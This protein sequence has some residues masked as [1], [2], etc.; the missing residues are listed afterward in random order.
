[1]KIGI[2]IDICKAIKCKHYINDECVLII[3]CRQN[4]DWINCHGCPIPPDCPHKTVQIVSDNIV[5]LCIECLEDGCP[6]GKE[7]ETR[8]RQ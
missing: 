7:N 1:M 2:D 3:A 4:G 6:L 5:A 8:N